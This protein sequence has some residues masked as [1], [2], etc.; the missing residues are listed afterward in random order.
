MM[1]KLPIL[2][3]VDWR[4]AALNI[5]VLASFCGVG[6]WF[7]GNNGILFAAAS[8]LILSVCLRALIARHHRKGIVLCKNGQFAEAIGEF[9]QS[10]EFFDRHRWID[11]YRGLTMLSS[12]H[13]Y[14][15]MA[16]VSLG[17]SHV[18]LNQ[19]DQAR[20]FYQTCL[21]SYPTSHMAIAA[22]QYLDSTEKA[23]TEEEIHG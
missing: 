3:P 23:S 5:L 7:E 1:S 14:I 8:F 12:G 13:S 11:Q 18:Q 2:K 4:H 22:L 6:Y 19:R 16:L 21:Q 17:F 15:E 20:C 9:K 10:L